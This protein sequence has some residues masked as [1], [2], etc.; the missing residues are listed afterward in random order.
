MSKPRYGWWSYAKYMARNY[1]DLHRELADIQA[2]STTANYSGEMRGGETSRGTENAALRQLSAIQQKEHDAVELAIQ[3]AGG[4]P[5]NGRLRVQ[6]AELVFFSRSHTLEGACRV[7]HI[8]YATG[9]RYQQ[10]FLC[11]IAKNFG[12]LER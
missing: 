1:P 7:L 8:G 10:D 2:T 3:S 6:L 12:L 9:K 5:G 11:D 4:K